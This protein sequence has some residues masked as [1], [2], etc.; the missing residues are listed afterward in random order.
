MSRWLELL[1][2][3]RNPEGEVRIAVVG[4]YV[5]LEDA[6]K[7]LRE[8]LMHGGLAHKL[9]T[10]SSGSRRKSST[11]LRP[12][13][14]DCAMPTASWFL[15]A[16]ENRGHSRHDLR[17]SVRA[18]QPSPYLGICLGMQCATIEYARSV[19]RLAGADSTE[20]DPQTPHRVIYKLRGTA[21]RGRNGGTM[22][23]GAWPCKIEPDSTAFRAY[24]ATEITERTATA[25]NSHCEYEKRSP[26]PDYES[27][28]APP[29]AS[30]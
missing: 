25:T 7:S 23:L 1:D 13:P 28:G 26:T 20:F 5:A 3:I 24:G 10:S 17:H 9:R 18:D 14:R 12:R 4:K 11:R 15:A 8:A 29:T 6:Y 30:T 16:S 27:P 19:S 21:R 22:R 2:R